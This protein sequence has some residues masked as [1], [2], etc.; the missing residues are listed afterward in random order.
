M[1]EAAIE[2]ILQYTRPLHT[3]S[4]S[5]GGLVL[6][7]TSTFFFV[8]DKGVAITC[9]HVLDL[10]PTADN[11]NNTFNQF[12]AERNRIPND[13]K[14]KKHLHGL[15]LKYKYNADTTVQLKNNF[16]NCF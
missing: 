4:R 8:N 16:L 7:G 2:N 9:K 10:I 11:V 3:I 15:E 12:K 1:F 5:Y 14:F 6:P 13:G